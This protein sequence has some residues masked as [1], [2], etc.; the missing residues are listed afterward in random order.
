MNNKPSEAHTKARLL[1]VHLLPAFGAK[2]L[3]AIGV[4]DIEAFKKV[5]LDAG[6]AA[7][8][9]N[10]QL[11]VVRK[12]LRIAVEWGLLEEA[13]AVRP[14]RA[15]KP[16]FSFLDFQEADLLVQAAETEW[17]AMVVT[18]LHTGLRLGELLALRWRH[19]DFERG[20]V[21]VCE[22]D[23]RG[24]IGTPKGHKTRI[25]P[26]N[27]TVLDALKA[28][29]HR[30]GPLVFCR[31]DG[32]RLS[33]QQCRR[34]LVRMCKKAGIKSVQW[35]ALRHTFASHMA[36]K[37]AP[38]KAVQDLLGHVTI[39]MTMRY[40]HSTPQASMA[41]VALLDSPEGV[42]PA[43][44]GTLMAHRMLDEGKCSNIN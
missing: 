6:Y 29:H 32:S 23:W 13:P 42:T 40:A 30:R 3:N 4:R 11:G 9:V 14:L 38:L 18:A 10:N 31:P 16:E 25:V 37:G 17:R 36:M 19:V 21:L 1:H 8:S 26:L 44:H 41:A 5:K 20:H 2:K 35:H 22:N 28:H 43:S 24:I 15:K 27:K 39:E 34:P 12:V 33:Y 7:K